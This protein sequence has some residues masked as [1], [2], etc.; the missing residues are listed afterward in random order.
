MIHGDGHRARFLRFLLVGCAATAVHYTILIVGVQLAGLS[1]VTAS[2]M[3]F[4][5]GALVSYRGNRSFTFRSTAAHGHAAP[6]FLAVLGVGMALNLALMYLFTA[7]LAWPYLV[8]QVLT[9]GLVLVWHFVGNAVWTFAA[10][11]P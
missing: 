5:G 10:R 8:A 4:C 6:R 11:H 7:V 3:G 1:P 2:G 9:T